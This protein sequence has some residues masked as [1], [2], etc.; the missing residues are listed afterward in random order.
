[1]VR[2]ENTA[3][4]APKFVLG[5]FSGCSIKHVLPHFYQC[6]TCP[7]KRERTLHLCF[8]NIKHAYRGY[9]KSKEDD[10]DRS[11]VHLVPLYKQ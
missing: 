6:I 10:S 2:L 4:D 5:Y 7:T 8:R 11:V 1:M 9:P 3:S